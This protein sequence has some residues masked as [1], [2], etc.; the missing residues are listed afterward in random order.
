MNEVHLTESLNLKTTDRFLDF[1]INMVKKRTFSDYINMLL[2]CKKPSGIIIGKQLQ[3]LY[4]KW[5]IDVVGN[6]TVHSKLYDEILNKQKDINAALGKLDIAKPMCGTL[7]EDLVKESLKL[8][9]VSL[10]RYGLQIYHR[11]KIKVWEGVIP[12][13]GG[14]FKEEDYKAELD[15]VVGKPLNDDVIPIVAISCKSYPGATDFQ[16][17]A[18]RFSLLKNLYPKMTC[19]FVART[20]KIDKKLHYALSRYFDGIF[21]L[22]NKQ[23]LEKFIETVKEAVRKFVIP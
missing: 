20:Y 18:L 2:N 1:G 7:F 17:D 8:G 22:D 3:K 10:E 9:I 5:K 12:I 13:K 19:L 23:R 21:I 15:V 16:A 14:K 11:E 6:I 4:N